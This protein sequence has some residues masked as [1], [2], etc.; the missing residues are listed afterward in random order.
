VLDKGLPK[1]ALADLL[2]IVEPYVDIWKLGWGTAYLD[3]DVKAKV[4][5]LRQHEV[6]ACTGG[7]LLELAWVQGRQAEFFA[8]AQECGFPCVEVSNGTVAMSREEQSELVRAAAEWFTVLAEVGS[9][10]PAAPVSPDVWVAD[11]ASDLAAGARWVITEGREGGSVGLYRPDG[12]VREELV[13]RLV[14][15]VG[16]ERLVFEAPRREQQAWLIRALGCEVS[17]GNIGTTDVL[18]VETLRLG[19]RSDTVRLPTRSGK[20]AAS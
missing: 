10:D 7:T 1:S 6:Q 9:K 15:D 12:T 8:W 16:A 2:G 18:G 11:A 14:D 5:M 19:L 20:D 13:A 17:L 3:P 4:A